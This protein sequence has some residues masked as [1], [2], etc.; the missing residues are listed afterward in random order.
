MSPARAHVSRFRPEAPR[1]KPRSRGSSSLA[2]TMLRRLGPPVDRECSMR[3]ERAHFRFFEPAAGYGRSAPRSCSASCGGD[4]RGPQSGD[5][6]SSSAF[7]APASIDADLP[8]SSSTACRRRAAGW[9]THRRSSSFRTALRPTGGWPWSAGSWHDHRSRSRA[10][11]R[12]STGQR[13]RPPDCR[14]SAARSRRQRVCRPDRPARGRWLCGR[15][16]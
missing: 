7:T 11:R 14:R 8:S 2:R 12:A 1:T 15:R 4:D 6:V 3:T 5:V 13:R 16:P 9:W 10:A